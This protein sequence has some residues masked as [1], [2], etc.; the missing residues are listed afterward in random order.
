MRKKKTCA[1]VSCA[2][3]ECLA[4]ITEEASDEDTV[5]IDL[6]APGDESDASSKEDKA[7]ATSSQEDLE[8]A[9]GDENPLI[10]VASKKFKLTSV[11]K[12]DERQK[13][14]AQ[15]LKQYASSKY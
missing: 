5:S 7:S 9:F 8:D 2:V 14:D 15:S 10:E 13:W 12:K 6:L 1:D 11:P 4:P 3:P